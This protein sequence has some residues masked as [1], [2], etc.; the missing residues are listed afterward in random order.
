MF[1]YNII[2]FKISYKCLIN[3]K[4]SYNIYFIAN[5]FH[6]KIYNFFWTI[7]KY[8]KFIK[9]EFYIKFL[10]IEGFKMFEKTYIPLNDGKVHDEEIFNQISL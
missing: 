8:I 9:V 3:P 7:Y 6:G 10:G 5:T 4:A 1:S 2:T